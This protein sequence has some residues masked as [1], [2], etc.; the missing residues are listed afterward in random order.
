[1]IRFI[2]GK[3]KARSSVNAATEALLRE[4]G[5]ETGM[6]DEENGKVYATDGTSA[7]IVPNVTLLKLV[8]IL[9]GTL[10]QNSISPPLTEGEIL[11]ALDSVGEP[12]YSWV[13]QLTQKRLRALHSSKQ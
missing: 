6:Y 11:K 7:T 10:L 9:S 12:F 1:M 2:G 5:G 13:V 3:K 4:N 8:D